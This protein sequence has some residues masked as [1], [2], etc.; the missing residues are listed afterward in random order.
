MATTSSQI[1]NFESSGTTS[2]TL[3]IEYDYNCSEQHYCHS[4]K[5]WQLKMG[6]GVSTCKLFR[7][8][9][10]VCVDDKP[11]FKQTTTLQVLFPSEW[12]CGIECIQYHNI[13]IDHAL[14]ISMLLL[15]G[16]VLIKEKKII[17]YGPL[18]GFIDSTF[19]P[20]CI[21]IFFYLC[22]VIPQKG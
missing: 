8:T 18:S 17:I 21:K 2:I 14:C 7:K 11:T 16:H 15:A 4:M 5:L 19:P 12:S 1:S 20:Y 6:I 9:K 22:V 10:L 3:A 13:A